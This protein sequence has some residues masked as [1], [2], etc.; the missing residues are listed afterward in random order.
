MDRMP[1]A[2]MRAGTTGAG[3]SDEEEPRKCLTDR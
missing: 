3:T 2:T 1:P